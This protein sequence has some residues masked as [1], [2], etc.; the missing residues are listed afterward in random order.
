MKKQ[1]FYKII[2]IAMIAAVL[3]SAPAGSISPLALTDTDYAEQT[4]QSLPLENT[5]FVL[6]QN[7]SFGDSVKMYGSATGGVG[8]C[9]YAY[10]WKQASAEKWGGFGFS[11]EIQKSFKPLKET[12]YNICIKVKDSSGIIETKY[13]DVEVINSL[14]NT[15]SVEKTTVLCGEPINMYGSARGGSGVY[16]YAFTYKQKNEDSFRLISTNL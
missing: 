12:T 9:Q 4:A 16:T 2:S 14:V 13:F 7:I 15:S 11:S 5:S 1:T 8:D 6:S 10:Y 3:C